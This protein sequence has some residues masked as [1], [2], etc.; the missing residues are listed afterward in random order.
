M[1]SV[2]VEAAAAAAVAVTAVVDTASVAGPCAGGGQPRLYSATAAACA[3]RAGDPAASWGG[4]RVD[5]VRRRL[6]LA[7]GAARV[8]R[9]GGG[10]GGMPPLR[11]G[12][13][14]ATASVHMV[15]VVVAAADGRGW[16][17]EQGSVGGADLS[18][19]LWTLTR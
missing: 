12:G 2:V 6:P 11:V 8:P 17:R 3:E 9:P 5:E 18:G 4:R 16:G 19:A 10:G 15:A 1:V 14:A 13:K 7:D